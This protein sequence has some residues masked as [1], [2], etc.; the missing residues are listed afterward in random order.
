MGFQIRYTNDF[1]CASPLEWRD[2]ITLLK[3]HRNSRR[4]SK[5][6]IGTD[7]ETISSFANSR[8]SEDAFDEKDFSDVDDMLNYL[9]HFG[10]IGVQ[11]YAGRSNEYLLV[12]NLETMKKSYGDNKMTVKDVRKILNG[13][14]KEFEDWAIGEC[15]G[16]MVIEDPNEEDDFDFD[17]I[18]EDDIHGEIIDSCFGYIG[19]DGLDYAEEEARNHLKRILDERN[20]ENE[21]KMADREFSI[22]Y[23]FKG[24]K[25][26]CPPD[27]DISDLRINETK[28]FPDGTLITR[29]K[30]K[31][32]K[33]KSSKKPKSKKKGLFKKRR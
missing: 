11:G 5:Q 22:T 16:W 33:K 4:N 2:D 29:D 8:F 17:Y 13:V 15:Y 1:D 14:Q 24:P 7:G 9:S 21:R 12:T 10:V 25:P 26:H 19:D 6:F 28:R 18:H 32:P 30:N 27:Y 23:S 3:K 31:K 20:K